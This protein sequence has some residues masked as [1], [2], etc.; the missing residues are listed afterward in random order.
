MN[1][2]LVIASV[3]MAVALTT[4]IFSTHPMEHMLK[5]TMMETVQKQTPNR[6]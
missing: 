4:G 6:A 1:K 5:M 3:L 2:S